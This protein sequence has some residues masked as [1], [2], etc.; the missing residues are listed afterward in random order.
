M[1]S[2]VLAALLLLAVSFAGAQDPTPTPTPAPIVDVNSGVHID[3]SVAYQFFNQA[4]TVNGNDSQ[5]AT[6][7]TLRV[8]V[9]NR[10]AALAKMIVM[11]GQNAQI[12]L[13]GAEYRR[14]LGELLKSQSLKFSPAKFDL[15]AYAA[16]G[17]K[18][19]DNATAS[20]FSALAGGGVDYHISQNV[21]VRAVDIG[22]LRS[23]LQSKGVIL[24]DHL[25]FAVG[26]SFRF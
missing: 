16:L 24:K 5:S 21:V 8:P 23:D 12:S 15:F 9:T 18:R 7:A 17:G 13:G 3:L 25:A 10:L 19:Q 22:Y 6:V 20:A 4:P 26:G 14:N 11:P 2:I 1:K